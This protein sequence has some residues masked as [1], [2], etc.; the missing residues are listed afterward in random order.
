MLRQRSRGEAKVK[1]Y[2]SRLYSQGSGAGGWLKS[3]GRMIGL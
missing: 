2:K 1:R 3:L